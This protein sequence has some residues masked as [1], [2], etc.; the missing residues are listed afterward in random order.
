M[1]GTEVTI[2][3]P[4]PRSSQIFQKIEDAP[5]NSRRQKGDMQK[6]PY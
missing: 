2:L 6:V 1:I 4:E 3:N 5:P